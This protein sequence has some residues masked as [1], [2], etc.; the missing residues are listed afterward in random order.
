M[1]KFLAKDSLIYPEGFITG[2]FGGHTKDAI[3]RFQKKHGIFVNGTSTVT[4]FFGPLTRASLHGECDQN[5]NHDREDNKNKG[6]KDSSNHGEN[7]RDD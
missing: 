5:D 2:F 3:K 1:Q 6:K 7:S 4:G